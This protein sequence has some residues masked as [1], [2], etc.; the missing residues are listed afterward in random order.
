[1]SNENSIKFCKSEKR[2]IV[3]FGDIS[4]FKA[5]MKRAGRDNL[6]LTFTMI[7]D[8]WKKFHDK[9]DMY[10][11]LGD[12]FMAIYEV[13]GRNDTSKAIHILKNAFKS[14]LKIDRIIEDSY[15]PRPGG[16]RFRIAEGDALKYD[17]TIDR[18]TTSDY[19]S[20][21]INMA[22]ELLQVREDIPIIIHGNFKELLNGHARK[23]GLIFKNLKKPKVD[24]T[25]IFDEDLEMLWV[26]I[27][28]KRKIN[29]KRVTQ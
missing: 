22:K 11:T 28:R 23:N 5:W 2:I 1:M 6:K 9:A 12:G 7:A 24:K 3:I 14:Y 13:N 16:F 15:S 18:K 8:E 26:A 17:E 27:E 29:R 4:G 20:Y 21:Y 19:I 25:E 10:K